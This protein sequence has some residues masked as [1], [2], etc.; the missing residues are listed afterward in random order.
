MFIIPALQTGEKKRKI[1]RKSLQAR[2]PRILGSR[3]AVENVISLWWVRV[4]TT[5]TFG[6]TKGSPP[7]I[8][9][10]QRTVVQTKIRIVRRKVTTMIVPYVRQSGMADHRWCSTPEMDDDLR[11]DRCPDDR[12][13]LFLSLLL[14]VEFRLEHGST[15]LAPDRFRNP[16]SRPIG[17]NGSEPTRES[18]SIPSVPR[19]TT[20]N[21]S[22]RRCER[23]IL[24]S[25]DIA[26]HFPR[27]LSLISRCNKRSWRTSWSYIRNGISK[28]IFSFNNNYWGKE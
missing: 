7:R 8:N 16:N 9:V 1:A 24:S 2:P 22:L 27:I 25:S 20:T 28:S 13:T 21:R 3:D 4:F 23:S 17:E 19:L 10:E 12:S 14:R 15:I 5:P 26:S 6:L 18:L 11:I